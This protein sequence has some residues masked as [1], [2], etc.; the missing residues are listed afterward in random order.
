LRSSARPTAAFSIDD[1][2]T[3]GKLTK[4]TITQPSRPGAHDEVAGALRR[5][6][7]VAVR[8]VALG[9]LEVAKP[10]I[11]DRTSHKICFIESDDHGNTQFVQ[12]TDEVA[13]QK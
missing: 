7:R 9:G 3:F 11:A 5:H 4:P 8:E 10:R 12:V 13:T 1:F 6:K 2:P